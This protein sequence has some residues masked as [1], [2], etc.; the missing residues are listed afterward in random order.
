MN[1]IHP[2]SIPHPLIQGD[3]TA[4]DMNISVVDASLG[5]SE[6][7]E[8]KI[9]QLFAEKAKEAEEKNLNFFNGTSY[10]LSDWHY[11]D[12]TLNLELATY[13]FKHRYGLVAMTRNKEIDETQHR[14]NGC[15]VG[16]TVITSDDKYIMVKLTSKTVNPNTYD[17]LGGMVETDVPMHP[18]TYLFDVLYQELEEEAGITQADIAKCTLK[19]MYAGMNGHVGFYFE[20]KLSI[21]QQELEA[22][23]THNTDID[24]DSLHFYTAN[25]YWDILSKHNPNKQFIASLYGR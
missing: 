22:R 24:I 21:S 25:E 12:N 4:A 18:H 13:D 6:K 23:F 5:L 16:S 19:M 2:T 8:H 3:F 15:F 1:N 11:Q 20:T 14:R 7:T 9:E 10:R 17:L